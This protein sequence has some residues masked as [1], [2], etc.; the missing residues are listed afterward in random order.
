MSA[1]IDNVGEAEEEGEVEEEVEDAA[2]EE[3]AGDESPKLAVRDAPGEGVELGEVGLGVL[4]AEEGDVDGE[5]GV[6]EHGRAVVVLVGHGDAGI[7]QA[8]EGGCQI[9]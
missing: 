7:F 5:H 4:G 1:V 2:V 9:E 8:G 6:G 3:G